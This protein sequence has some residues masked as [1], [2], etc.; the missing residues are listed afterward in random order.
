[1]K[2]SK[3]VRVLCTV[4]LINAALPSAAASQVC[5]AAK[6]EE[7]QGTVLFRMNSK[8]TRIRLDP[9]V[10]KGRGLCPGQQV[11]AQ[12]GGGL[13]IRWGRQSKEIRASRH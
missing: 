10:D 9:D 6:I 1:M 12:Q 11:Q 5:R 2:L 8:A 3:T 13:R 7:I 4:T